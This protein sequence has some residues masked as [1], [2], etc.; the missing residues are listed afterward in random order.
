MDCT[1]P[2]KE[3]KN[4]EKIEKFLKEAVGGR[5][6]N[7]YK[8]ARVVLQDGMFYK[9]KGSNEEVDEVIEGPEDLSSM[10]ISSG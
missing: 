8:L 7:T 4:K 10:T 1:T 5:Q 9:Y 3:K 6:A 2:A